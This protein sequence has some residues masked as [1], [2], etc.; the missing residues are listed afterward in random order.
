L[1]SNTYTYVNGN[2]INM[3][4]PDGH[5]PWCGGD[6][7]PSASAASAPKPVVGSAAQSVVNPIATPSPAGW[8]GTVKAAGVSPLDRVRGAVGG[9]FSGLAERLVADAEGKSQA[10]IREEMVWG[11]F[12]E[13]AGLLDTVIN[14]V[15]DQRLDERIVDSNLRGGLL[16]FAEKY[17]GLDRDSVYVDIGGWASMFIP[18]PGAV[19]AKSI[20]MLGRAS[21]TADRVAAAAKTVRGVETTAIVER[22]LGRAGSRTRATPAL[23]TGDQVATKAEVGGGGQV[24]THYTDA[25]GVAGIT[26]VGPLN[27]GDSVGVGSLKFGQGGNSF[28][29]GAPGDNFVTDLGLDATSRQLEGIG[30]FGGRQQYAIQ[31]SHETALD[32]GVRPMMVRDNIF[33]IPGGSCMTGACV[34]TRVR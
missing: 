17:G 14:G 15:Q 26:G 31:F 34:V 11:G 8:G 27:V 25:D 4:D 21:R 7:C 30:V 6:D 23:R 16:G 24:F 3:S 2:P 10:E 13:I 12:G 33:T 28:L 29:A 22:T 20:S 18:I 5:K 9:A 1:T 19:A 32:A